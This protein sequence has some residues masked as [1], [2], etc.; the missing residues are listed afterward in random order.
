MRSKK[1]LTNNDL[2]NTEAY[3]FDCQTYI[4]PHLF[5]KST[6]GLHFHVI[7]IIIKVIILT[8]NRI[9]GIM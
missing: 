9:I 2:T 8:I 1:V 7:V 6:Y 4:Q 3:I 5:I